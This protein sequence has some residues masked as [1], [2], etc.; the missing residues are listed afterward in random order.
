MAQINDQSMGEDLKDVSEMV[1]GSENGSFGENDVDFEGSENGVEAV[2]GSDAEEA[3]EYYD[4]IKNMKRKR[5]EDRDALYAPMDTE[6]FVEEEMEGDAKRKATYKIL[7]NRGL[8]PHRKKENRN[9][10]VKKRMKYDKAL[11]KLSS[12]RAVAVDK[13][14]LSKYDGERTGIKANLARSTKF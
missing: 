9:P 4:E 10:R 13:T 2:E 7:A 12:T 11:K 5:L 14:K 3:N 6:M 1:D 8:T